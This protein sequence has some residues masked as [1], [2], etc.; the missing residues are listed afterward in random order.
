[1][2]LATGLVVSAIVV[3]AIGGWWGWAIGAAQVAIGAA[4][5][6]R[7][8]SPAPAAAAILVLIPAPLGATRHWTAHLPGGCGCAALSHPP[9]GLVSL[10]G[11]VVT[12]DVLLLVLAL[13][14]TAT[15]R[16]ARVGKSS[17]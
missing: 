17:P 12:L 1:M 7:P 13:W 6:A 11:L 9:P 4:V 5:V 16:R 10:T 14:L 3:S 8:A 2:I 15:N